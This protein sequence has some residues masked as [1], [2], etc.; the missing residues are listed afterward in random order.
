MQVY[1][2]DVLHFLKASCF[3]CATLWHG[4]ACQTC[5]TM[6]VLQGFAGTSNGV[7]GC[8][9]IGQ[10]LLSWKT[11]KETFKYGSYAESTINLNGVKSIALHWVLWHIAVA[12]GHRGC[13]TQDS[14]DIKSTLRK[15]SISFMCV[16]GYQ[17]ELRAFV[18][19]AGIA[20]ICIAKPIKFS[21]K[22]VSTVTF[23]LFL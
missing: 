14:T 5:W 16:Q 23:R 18:L 4:I 8:H 3:L 9:I 13:V 1:A 22:L 10:I 7:L 6:L 21:V 2:W 11:W 20:S 12:I 15:H 17:K 19:L